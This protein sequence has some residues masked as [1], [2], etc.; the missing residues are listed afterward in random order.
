MVR[1]MPREWSCL[2][3]VWRWRVDKARLIEGKEVG[4]PTC[5][6]ITGVYNTRVRRRN[7]KRDKS[8]ALGAIIIRLNDRYRYV[9]MSRKKVW[10]SIMRRKKKNHLDLNSKDEN[11]PSGNVC[12]FVRKSSILFL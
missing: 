12:K 8:S 1:Y 7:Y 3:V 10:N 9:K 2:F 11:S 5:W 4:C 6:T